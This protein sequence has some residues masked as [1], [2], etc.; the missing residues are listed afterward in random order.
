[1]AM[2]LKYVLITPARNEAE[3]IETTIH[4]VI[5]QNQRPLKW[6]IVSD[7]STDGTDDIV[8]RYCLK[9]PF[10][11]LVRI[12][13]RKIKSFAAKVKAF[14]TGYQHVRDLEFDLV[15][16]LDADLAFDAHYYENVLVEFKK[17]PALG[18]SGG[19]R[20][21]YIRGKLCM[22]YASISPWCVCAGVQLFRRQCYEAI[23]GYLTIDRVEDT[24]AEV[25]A[26]MHG[27]GVRRAPN[28][29]I[30]HLRSLGAASD[31]KL[32][33]YFKYGVLEYTLGYHPIYQLVKFINR[34]RERPYYV[35]GSLLRLAGYGW[36][37]ISQAE[38]VLPK[39]VVDYLR[40]EQIERLKR[41]F[42][43]SKEKD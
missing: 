10:M 29:R 9:Y 13:E 12:T 1:M 7:G 35:L 32:R 18:I 36:A 23:G 26:R 8:K 20:Y 40:S 11:E 25:M 31:G 34:F 43:V 17:D 5:N 6:V 16:N 14:E 4:S 27:W 33:I 21:E 42:G 38:I 39:P 37:M 22:E 15:G 24:A 41:Y 2:N 28:A 3:H 19:E 30:I